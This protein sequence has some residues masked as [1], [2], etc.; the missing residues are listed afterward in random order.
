M[1]YWIDSDS[2]KSRCPPINDDDWLYLIDRGVNTCL[3]FMLENPIYA[4]AASLTLLRESPYI[5][6]FLIT[7]HR[8]IVLFIDA[9]LVQAPSPYERKIWYASIWLESKITARQQLLWTTLGREVS[10]ISRSSATIGLPSIY[11]ALKA[12]LDHRSTEYE[13]FSECYEDYHRQAAVLD[14]IVDKIAARMAW[15]RHRQRYRP[16]LHYPC[17]GAFR[18]YAAPCRL[19]YYAQVILLD[20]DCCSLPGSNPCD[21]YPLL[22][23]DLANP[24]GFYIAVIL[25]GHCKAACCVR[26]FFSADFG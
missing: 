17:F 4:V 26:F 25:I 9:D 16:L 10:L 24:L 8:D 21:K 20:S 22:H 11:F 7:M 2:V 1:A 15:N 5:D 19:P 23:Q 12:A 18:R 6:A 13:D 14:K 3:A